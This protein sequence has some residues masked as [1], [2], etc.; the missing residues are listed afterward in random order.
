MTLNIIII[1][2]LIIVKLYSFTDTFTHFLSQSIE[3]KLHQKEL[4][5]VE[6]EAKMREE[7]RRSQHDKDLLKKATRQHKDRAA[8]NEHTVETLGA[9][10]DETVS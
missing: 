2:C 10:L 5:C 9:Q 3:E 1:V 8:Q 7:K 6:L 4:R